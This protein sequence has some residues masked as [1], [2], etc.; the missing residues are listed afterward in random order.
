MNLA[1]TIASFQLT[2][3]VAIA[4]GIAGAYRNGTRP[5]SDRLDIRNCQ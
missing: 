3:I 1:V 4:Y 5:Q 2:S